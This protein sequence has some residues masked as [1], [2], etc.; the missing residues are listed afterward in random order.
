MILSNF[1]TK[2]PWIH[3]SLG[4][5]IDHG[6]RKEY[7]VKEY[8]LSLKEEESDICHVGA[9]DRCGVCRPG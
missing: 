5:H 7:L 8:M 6:I 1:C 4:L 2:V 9:C 3:T